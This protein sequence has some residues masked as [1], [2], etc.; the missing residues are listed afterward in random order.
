VEPVLKNLVELLALERVD[1]DLFRGTS[2]NLGWGS[3][4]GGQV[5]GQA[6]SAATQTV[7]PDRPVHSAHGYFIRAGELDRPIVY[8]VD[9]LRDGRSFSTRRVVAVQEGAAIFSLAASFQVEETGFEH[10][11]AM[12]QVAAPESLHSERELALALGERLP[13]AMRSRATGQ[14]PIEIRPVEPHNPFVPV[15]RAPIR[16]LWYRA[17]DRLPDDPALH[18]YLLAY[19]SDFAFLGTALDPHGVSPMTPKMQIASLDHAIWFHRSFR[20]DEWLLYDVE[21]PNASGARGLVRGRFFDRAGRLVASTVQ[22]GL[23]RKRSSR[24]SEG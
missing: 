8:Q 20:V 6:L 15:A 14:R 1:R 11:D 5:L 23:M 24:P 22:E 12:P 4:F 3:I 18:R 16:R 2:Q 19:A 7:T 9:R 21:S 10:Q 17:V 13:E